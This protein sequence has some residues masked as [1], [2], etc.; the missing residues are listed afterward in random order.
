MTCLY[1]HLLY[2]LPYVDYEALFDILYL[3]LQEVTEASSGLVLAV[4]PTSD[5]IY[6]KVRADNACECIKIV[7]LH[8]SQI[9]GVE[10][11]RLS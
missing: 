3:Q 1:H 11:C 4:D 6:H 10:T 8:K 9:F 2:T 5:E 7:G